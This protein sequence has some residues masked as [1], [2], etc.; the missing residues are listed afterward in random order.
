[1]PAAHCAMDGRKQLEPPAT[2][3]EWA[4]IPSLTKG[5]GPCIT[6]WERTGHPETL[7]EPVNSRK[8]PDPKLPMGTGA[9]TVGVSKPRG[10]FVQGPSQRKQPELFLLLHNSIMKVFF[11]K[12]DLTNL[13]KKFNKG[14]NP[15]RRKVFLHALLSPSLVLTATSQ[16]SN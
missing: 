2:S 14:I 3:Q 11:L 4:Q 15:I 8:T 12:L 16:N 7:Q 5:S 6:V 10:S 13:D 1:M 9:Q